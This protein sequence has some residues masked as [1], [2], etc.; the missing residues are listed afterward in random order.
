MQHSSPPGSEQETKLPVE[1][2]TLAAVRHFPRLHSLLD[3]GA[4]VVDAETCSP[5]PPSPPP[6]AARAK[7]L[8]TDPRA[9]GE[10]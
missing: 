4:V 8:L 10:A 3:D 6:L 2:L 9:Y 7:S 1:H 5:S